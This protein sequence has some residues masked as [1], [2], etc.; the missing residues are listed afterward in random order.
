M[1]GF[2]L[3]QNK[4]YNCPMNKAKLA[5]QP[6]SIFAKNMVRVA[7]EMALGYFSDVQNLTIEKKGHQD[8]VSEADKNVETL[9]VGKI[10]EAFPDDSI[11]GEEGGKVSGTSAFT[12]VIDPIDGTSNFVSGIPSW[13]VAVALVEDAEVTAG[14][15]FEPVMDDLYFGF[16]GEG[17]YCNDK[18][19]SVSK[20]K[21]L[22]EGSVGVGFSNRS[23]DGFI[24]K[25][26]DGIVSEGGVFYRNASGALSLCYVASG[27]LI[28]YTEDHMNAWDFLAGQLIVKE[29][30]GM[31]EEQSA[32]EALERGGRVV[33][34][35]PAVFPKLLSLTK[36]SMDG[37]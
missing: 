4:K 27:K 15:I 23:K 33:A 22:A 6:R 9:I 8:F 19:L 25:L 21:S 36:D 24:Q 34:A 7:G 13:V 31:I 32:K 10:A 28:G 26:V 2:R 30:G 35:T 14:F 16:R 5:D 3:A 17:S 37:K 1:V 12:W 29:A 20:A 18:R 11:L